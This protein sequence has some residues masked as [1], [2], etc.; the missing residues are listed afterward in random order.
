[1]L[2]VCLHF[3]IQE[4]NIELCWEKWDSIG[5]INLSSHM[6][7]DVKQEIRSVFRGPMG[8]DPNFPFTF[9]QGAG[10]DV[11]QL[12]WASKCDLSIT[13]PRNMGL[14][15]EEEFRQKMDMCILGSFEFCT[16]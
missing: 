1:M 5:K 7:E 6:N 10:E 14:L 4:D 9:L 2:P 3:H 13:F 11:D 8:N 12:P 15:T 16:V